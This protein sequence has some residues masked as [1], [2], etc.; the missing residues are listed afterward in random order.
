MTVLKERPAR[1]LPGGALLLLSGC[2]QNFHY[3]L[4]TTV[5]ENEPFS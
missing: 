5:A 2:S 3:C 4:R 1:R